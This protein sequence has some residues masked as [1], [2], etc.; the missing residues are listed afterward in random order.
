MKTEV[1]HPEK[2]LPWYV[3]NT[4]TDEERRKVEEHLK[5]CERCRSEV[6]Y[7]KA[8]RSQVKTTSA[9]TVYG[10]LG[11]KRLLRDIKKEAQPSRRFAFPRWQ[12]ALAIAASLIIMLQSVI[13]YN[14]WQQSEAIT[15]LSGHVHGG[16]VLQVSFAPD[17]NEA[18]IRKVLQSVEGSIID[19]PGAIGIYRIRLDLTTEKKERINELIAILRSRPD[20][21]IHVARE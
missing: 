11:L 15:T 17:A 5:E 21:V 1:K 3:N 16:V 13:L 10:K 14:Y 12:P 19:G 6:K 4:L 8:L 18:K 9:V 7:L 2:I 20:V